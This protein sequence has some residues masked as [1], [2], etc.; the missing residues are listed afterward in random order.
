MRLNTL[1]LCPSSREYAI[2]GYRAC[3]I[4]GTIGLSDRD[5]HN[6]TLQ[7]LP[8]HRPPLI[9]G[10]SACTCLPP[11]ATPAKTTTGTRTLD[12]TGGQR[13]RED[14]QTEVPTCVPL[15]GKRC[16]TITNLHSPCNNFS[17]G[18]NSTCAHDS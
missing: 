1:T 14:S 18:T 15:A 7:F 10:R 13:P 3:V 5:M 6:H 2:S 9:S 12:K 17:T 11:G 4:T 8:C 16:P